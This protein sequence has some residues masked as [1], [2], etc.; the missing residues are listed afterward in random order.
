ME[1]HASALL[2]L[3]VKE[4][5]TPYDVFGTEAVILSLF[6]SDVFPYVTFRLLF[7]VHVP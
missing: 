7:A 6:T 3:A 1:F 2:T 5:S 4:A